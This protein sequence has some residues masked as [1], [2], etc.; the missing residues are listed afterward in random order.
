M[1]MVISVVLAAAAFCGNA[2]AC[3]GKVEDWSRS[4]LAMRSV[5][6]HFDGG[7]WTASVDQ[8]NGAKHQAM[9]C[10]AQHAAAQAATTAQL[11]QWMGSPDERVRCPSQPCDAFVPAPRGAAEVWLYRWRANHD[12]LGF[13]VINGRVSRAQWFYVGE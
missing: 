1:K 3:E 12:R 11:L 6:G 5:R 8:W 10:L 13:A 9:Q 4:F 7:A 2:G